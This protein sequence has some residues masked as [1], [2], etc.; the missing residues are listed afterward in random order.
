MT[1]DPTDDAGKVR[2]LISDTDPDNEVFADSEIDTFL[3]LEGGNL[4]LAAAQAL[5]TIASNELQ[6]LKVIQ[7]LDL[8]TDGASMSKELRARADS[9]RAQADRYLADGEDDSG[10]EIAEFVLNPWSYRDRLTNEALREQT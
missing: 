6:V 8:R 3:E 10:F 7:I 4:R 2:L 5:D 1:Y 9:L